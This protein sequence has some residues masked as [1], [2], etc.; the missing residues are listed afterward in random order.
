MTRTCRSRIARALA[1]IALMFALPVAAQTTAALTGTVTDENGKPLA[2]VTVTVSSPALQ[3][4]RSTVTGPSG[5]YQFSALPPGT[6]TINFTHR[7]RA[8]APE[9]I[10][11]H[12]SQ[13][14]RVDVTMYPAVVIT[15]FVYARSSSVLE[16]TPI[17]TS[18]PLREIDR[19]P[20]LRNQFAT[21]QFAPGVTAN[22]FTGGQLQISGGPGYDN[23][24][25][26]NGV[27]V[28]E[29]TRSQM[30]PMY[31]EDAIEETTLLTG[32]IPAEYG[33]FTGG[34][35]NTITRSGGNAFEASLRDSLSNPKWSAQTPAGEGRED[36]LNHVW[37]ATAGGALL[38]DR[39]WFFSSG[40]WARN[41][42]ARQTIAIPAFTGN[43]ATS[44]SPRIDY[45][46]GNDQKRFEAK[47]TS[48]LGARHSLVGSYFRVHTGGTNARFNANLYDLASLT[49]QDDPDS[50]AALHYDGVLAQ[51]VL[52]QANLSRRTM[53]LH[54][55]AETTDRISGTLL[56]DRA[57]ANTRFHSPSRCAVCEDERR[58]NDDMIVKANAFLDTGRFGSHDLVAGIDRFT[59]HRLLE[60]HQSGSDFSIFVTRVQFRD[61]VVYPVITPTTANG[62]GTFIR[63]SP[64]FTPADYNE[65]RTDS[66]FV[67]DQWDFGAHWSISAGVRYDR[68]HARDA[69]GLLASDSGRFAPRLSAHF[70]PKG[71]G[72]QRFS[73]SYA[74]YTTRIG[75]AIASANQ[76]AGNAASID[77]AYK[78]P[79]INAQNLTVTMDDAIR[80]LFAYFDAQQGGTANTSATNLRT[81]GTRTVPGFAAYYDG[82]LRSPYV[83]EITAGYGIQLASNAYAK[84]DL[85]AR[86]WHDFFVAGVTPL[87]IPVDLLLIRNSDNI[88]RTY[89]GVQLQAHWNP[90]VYQTGVHY[91]WSKLRGNDEGENMNAGPIVNFDPSI[92]YAEFMSY[93]R[94]S[95][96]GYLSGDQR[97]RLRA[98]AGRSFGPF[99]VSVLQTYDSG[100]PYS[101]SA[102]IRASGYT[103]A[104]ANPGYNSIP[105]GP[106][107]FSDRGSF[108]TEDVTSTN[109]ALRFTH[110]FF[111]AQADILNIFNEQGIFDPLRLGTG[112]TTAAS[113]ATL[114]TFNP[115]TQTPV[116]GTHYQ[117]ASNFGQPL[118]N[119][120]YQTPRTYR[121]SVGVRF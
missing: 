14:S 91:T 84:V 100:L 118:N 103:G 64:I 81:G 25:L 49:T 75:D 6:Y 71:D 61:G 15:E 8:R 67:S 51:N 108:R 78:G 90:G 89:R 48:T 116:E 68:N 65:L 105:N 72:R 102:Q 110:A 38:R 27:V 22:T 28:T 2:S 57:N 121:V 37:E 55:G 69:D 112:V 5:A 62:G 46:E 13:I 39:L 87:G 32:A 115:Y 33:R 113:S 18:L 20:I 79:A 21:A 11:L 26:V 10:D 109:L 23:L 94:F 30:R 98:W 54:S 104:P 24:A 34:V 4:S 83:R 42:Q 77:F 1:A 58:N 41:D 107:Y 43:P 40:R 50:L 120:A 36:S 101:A 73:A 106:Y 93:D 53:G 60:D 97:H 31:V 66:A 74:E 35:V 88:Q 45:S 3:G 119:L 85:I 99:F 9:R 82:S 92:Y 7:E 95:P 44:A 47:L 29:N 96:T 52:L 117:R 114:Q 76:L 80:Q 17:A 59:E 86:D 12:L 63:W 111:F 70:D 56:L 16:T 19:L